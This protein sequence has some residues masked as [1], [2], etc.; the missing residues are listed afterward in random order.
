MKTTIQVEFSS[1]IKS[2]ISQ[3]SK[4]IIKFKMQKNK[5]KI[6]KLDGFN[7]HALTFDKIRYRNVQIAMSC[8]M[9]FLHKMLFS[10]IEINFNEIDYHDNLAFLFS[11]FF[12][13]I[14]Y[15]MF[16]Y[17]N[18]LFIEYEYILLQN[19]I[20]SLCCSL[21]WIFSFLTTENIKR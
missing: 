13:I 8:K 3:K 10:C 21:N 12:F 1:K 4:T 7:V 16:K 5:T 9:I 15:S 19:T 20:V 17:R 14:Y 2:P 18:N 6:Q 11:S